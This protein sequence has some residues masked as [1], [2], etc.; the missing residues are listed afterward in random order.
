MDLGKVRPLNI[1]LQQIRSLS[2]ALFTNV[3]NLLICQSQYWAGKEKALCDYCVNLKGFS[4][5][6]LLKHCQ[7]HNGPEGKV[8]TFFENPIGQSVPIGWSHSFGR[9]LDWPGIGGLDRIDMDWHAPLGGCQCMPIRSNQPILSQSKANRGTDL[10]W[11]GRSQS[12]IFH[13]NPWECRGQSGAN[14][15]LRA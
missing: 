12:C 7:R 3:W 14:A 2:I 9:I 5:F 11:Q 1:L 15:G 4:A 8:L 10:D 13:A 6:F